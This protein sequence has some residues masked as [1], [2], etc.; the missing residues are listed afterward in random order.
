MEL[1]D[2]LISYLKTKVS[3]GQMLKAAGA[4]FALAAVPGAAA[5]GASTGGPRTVSFPFFPATGGTYSTETLDQIFQ[6]LLTY[7]YA[8]ATGFTLLITQLGSKLPELERLVLQASLAQTQYHID[9][10]QKLMP[11]IQPLYTAISFDISELPTDLN[12]LSLATLR[13]HIGL[14]A[15]SLYITAAREFA[16]LGQPRLVQYATQISA[17]YAEFEGIVDTVSALGGDTTN[18][19][20]ND[21]AFEPSLFLYT[22]DAV[23]ALKA[24]GA[25]GG[26]GPQIP[27]PGRAAVLAAAGAMA[28]R[29]GEQTP[30]GPPTS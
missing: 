5:A 3:R 17:T 20:P 30:S 4:G 25:I 26:P 8:R 15:T 23:T 19:P 22:R 1:S 28:S 21:E 29:V 24:S 16:E 7:E 18:I 12:A 14:E 9:F 10:L 2:E 27:Y 6:N 11:G 13:P